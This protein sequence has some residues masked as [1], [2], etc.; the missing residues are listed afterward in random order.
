MLAIVRHTP[1]WVFALL[2]F[3]IWLGAQALRP[4]AVPLWRLVLVPAAFIVWGVVS[5][6]QRATAAPLLGV[7]GLVTAAIGVSGLSAGYVVGWLIRF[8]LK[9]RGERQL[10]AAAAV[11]RVQPE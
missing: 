11:A 2:A 5:L 10:D 8:A 3:L 4:R 7:D 9:Y 1:L 6:L